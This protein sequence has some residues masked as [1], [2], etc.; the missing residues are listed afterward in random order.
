MSF[1]RLVCCVGLDYIGTDSLCWDQIDKRPL[2]VNNAL[3]FYGS[4]ISLAK[5]KQIRKVKVVAI[6]SMKCRRRS[7][8]PSPP[9]P[10]KIKQQQPSQLMHISGEVER[11]VLWRDKQIE[12]A[13]RCRKRPHVI[14]IPRSQKKNQKATISTHA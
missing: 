4:W 5:W 1:C 3:E 13:D 6:K 9:L 14:C 12:K 10:K 2:C 7:P 8:C 11:H